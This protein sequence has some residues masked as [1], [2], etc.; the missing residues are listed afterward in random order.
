MPNADEDDIK[1]VAD[2]RHSQV[3]ELY[4]QAYKE[5]IVAFFDEALL[6]GSR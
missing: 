1:S 4:T 2:R 6:S 3:P 5:R